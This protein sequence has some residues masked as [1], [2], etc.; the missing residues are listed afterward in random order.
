[1]SKHPKKS[2]GAVAREELLLYLIAEV[3]R[4]IDRDGGEWD[5]DTAQDARARL[6]KIVGKVRKRAADLKR[7]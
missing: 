4:V 1:M 2:V 7:S 6:D 5:E 3:E